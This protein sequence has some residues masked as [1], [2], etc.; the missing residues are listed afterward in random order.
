[1]VKLNRSSRSV[2]FLFIIV[3]IASTLIYARF[4]FVQTAYASPGPHKY[5][6][7][8]TDHATT[9]LTFTAGGATDA[10]DND[11]GTYVDIHYEKSSGYLNLTDFT[12]AGGTISAVDL[13]MK[14]DATAA[15]RGGTYAIDFSIDGT[16]W[17]TLV[18][19]TGDAHSVPTPAGC[20]VWASVSRPGGGSWSWIDISN[21]GF[22]IVTTKQSAGGTA[23]GHFK[24]YEAW[25]TVHFTPPVLPTLSIEP[26]SKVDLT[27]TPPA[28]Q[29]S[30]TLRPDADGTYDDWYDDASTTPGSG[31]WKNW[32]EDVCNGDTD[33]NWIDDEYYSQSSTLDDAGTQTWSIAKVKVAVCAKANQTSNDYLIPTVLIGGQEYDG[34]RIENVSTTW[35]EYTS[36]WGLSPATN[37]EWTWDEIDALE[38]GVWG[39]AGSDMIWGNWSHALAMCVSQLYV[40]VLG[41]GIRFDVY[42]DYMSAFW[43]WQFDMWYNPDVLHGVYAR[44]G[45]PVGVDP[46]GFLAS[47]GGTLFA[48]GGPGWNNTMGKLWLT[49]GGLVGKAGAV[50]GGGRIACFMM[51]PVYKGES[52]LR[53]AY[54]TLVYNLTD[55][56]TPI[57][58]HSYFRNVDTADLPTASFTKTPQIAPDPIEGYNVTFNGAG[59]SAPGGKTIDEYKWYFGRNFP[60]D[61]LDEVVTE[62]DPTIKYNYTSR[63]PSGKIYNVTLTVKDSGGVVATTKDSF[64]VKAHDIAVLYIVLWDVPEAPENVTKGETA[65][66]NASIMNQGDYNEPK[67]PTMLNI[68]CYYKYPGGLPTLIGKNTGLSVNAGQMTNTTFTWDTS[69][70]TVTDEDYIVWAN[71]SFVDYEYE[72]NDNT[73]S[74]IGVYV[75]PAAAPEFPL[76]LA[77]EMAIAVAVIY[78]WWKSRHRKKAPKTY[79]RTSL[80]P[81]KQA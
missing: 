1:M 61:T 57:K 72:K 58:G 38:A 75:K 15:T 12:K 19:A 66:I 48:V 53:L 68:T 40:E 8:P 63:S 17:T 77:M 3:L 76:G 67:A 34:E 24:A 36:I 22:R 11:N 29:Y 44:A 42:I 70:L 9:G 39:E 23:L 50:T 73:G 56:Y 47:G 31:F 14:Y 28:E 74:A 46:D 21:I 26:A 30:I 7:V 49:S 54:Y 80:H 79:P 55:Y 25:V 18:A 27:L 59:S 35:T 78:L 4:M 69:P 2:S 60:Y 81:P 45:Q 33:Y 10:Y 6:S 16:S 71:A 5:Q 43:Q 37:D 51:E 52:N 65:K 32:D 20:D 13:K 41:P 62:T 64:V